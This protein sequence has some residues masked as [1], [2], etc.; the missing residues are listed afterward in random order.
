MRPIHLELSIAAAI[1][2]LLTAETE[3]EMAHQAAIFILESCSNTPTVSLAQ[4]RGLAEPLKS[5]KKLLKIIKNYQRRLQHII[6]DDFTSSVLPVT[7]FQERIWDTL[8]N[9]KDTAL[10][11]PTSAGKS[12]VLMRWL[13]QSLLKIG[14]DAVVAYIVP[15]RALIG[16]VRRSIEEM[17]L[18]YNIRPRISTLPTLYQQEE[19]RQTILVMTQERIERLF[20]VNGNLRFN[21]IVVDEAHKL[22][23]GP[24]GV[25]LQRVI[26]ESLKRFKN[27]KVILAAP[28]ANNA[29]VLLPYSDKYQME[30]IKDNIVSDS[31]PTVLQNL[32]WVT[33]VKRRKARWNISLI[34][35]KKIGEIGELKLKGGPTGKK[36]RLS[37]IAF[38]LGGKEGG[39]IVFT[40]GAAEAEEVALLL[41]EHVES[42]SKNYQPEDENI[43]LA[44]LIKDAVH[45][46]YPLGETLPFGIGIHYGDMPEISRREQERLFD[47]G[48]LLFLVCTSTLLEGV[49]LPCRNLFIWGPRQGR[50]N[51]MSEHA[52]WNLAGRAGRWGR[53]FAG[54]VFCID[55]YDKKQWPHG[56]PSHRQARAVDHSGSILLG[57]IENFKLFVESSDPV[58]ASQANRY[59]EQILGELVSTKLDGRN[60]SSIGWARWCS[61]HQLKTLDDIVESSLKNITAPPELIRRHSGMRW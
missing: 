35:E 20:A 3:S 4:K 61:N 47:E 30:K 38:Q 39:N 41:R 54:N 24:R 10:T 33:P 42:S 28:H 49:N 12:Y 60:L 13:A 48:K 16:Q 26:D 53:E 14:K 9:K 19:N 11:A 2:A 37:A 34:K 50:G 59:F 27:C 43:E 21:I 51:P 23:E 6:F 8:G 7:D 17:L 58:S 15:S 46:S 40:N 5:Q 44:K 18:K 29:E 25:I 36:K 31:R 56:P 32:F 1:A 45:E 52:F 22:G 57:D 55:V